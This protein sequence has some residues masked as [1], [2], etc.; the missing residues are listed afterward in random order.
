MIIRKAILSDIGLLSGLFDQYRIFYHQSSDIA[1][2]KQFISERI[3]QND[4]V[5]FVAF[6]DGKMIGFT[7]LYPIFSSVGMKR[8]WLLND[9]FVT[10]D[11]RGS[12]AADALLKAAQDMGAETSSRWLMLQTATD[13]HRAQKVYERNGWER[14][15]DYLVFNYRYKLQ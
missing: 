9:L 5:L 6:R 3:Q 8:A 1:S 14:N 4:S 11:A 2:A 7:Q 13:N 15:S 12:G 10:E